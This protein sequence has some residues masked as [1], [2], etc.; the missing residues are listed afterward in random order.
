MPPQVRA[1]IEAV[2]DWVPRELAAKQ[3]DSPRALSGA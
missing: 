3:R 2:A 1:F